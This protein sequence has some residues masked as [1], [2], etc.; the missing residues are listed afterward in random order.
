LLRLEIVH[1][2]TGHCKTQRG[3]APTRLPAIFAYK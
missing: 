1:A 3:P 2:G